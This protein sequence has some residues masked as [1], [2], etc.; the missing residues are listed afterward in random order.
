MN[1]E[2]ASLR[3]K[4]QWSSLFNWGEDCMGYLRLAKGIDHTGGVVAATR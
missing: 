2:Q 4:H 3:F 1:A